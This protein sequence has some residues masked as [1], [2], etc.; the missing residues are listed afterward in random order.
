[1]VSKKITIVNSIK[2]SR[3]ISNIIA[4]YINKWMDAQ[5]ASKMHEVICEW[6]LGSC[7]SR[8]LFTLLLV[9][10]NGGSQLPYSRVGGTGG[11]CVSPIIWRERT[12][13]QPQ[14]QHFSKSNR[15]TM[16]VVQEIRDVV[17]KSAILPLTYN[18]WAI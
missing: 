10:Y 8:S 6:P 14:S 17:P 7:F 4:K 5:K 1:M 16:K 18:F 13:N 15:V 11:A 9:L 12:N 2:V 3:G